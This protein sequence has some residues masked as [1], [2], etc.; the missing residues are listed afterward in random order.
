MTCRKCP[1]N[2]K[3]SWRSG[4]C[5]YLS[6]AN[7]EAANME[8]PPSTYSIFAHGR[9]Y[10][11]RKWTD[12][13]AGHGALRA[14]R[15]ATRGQ[16]PDQALLEHI[17]KQRFT[18]EVID[19]GAN[20]GGYTLWLAAIC[21]LR[22]HAFEPLEYE[23]LWRNVAL[24]YFEREVTVHQVALGAE[25]GW[26]RHV[27]AGQIEPLGDLDTVPPGVEIPQHRLD[28]YE[29][30]QLAAVRVD[31][32]RNAE[33]RVLRGAELTIKRHRP[34]IYAGTS[35]AVPILEPLGY[36]LVKLLGDEEV[37]EWVYVGA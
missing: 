18:G 4:P 20:V 15:H 1:H 34:V 12:E 25:A 10:R 35:A 3:W 36:E 30:E 16:P 13:L 5:T 9:R 28:D 23:E 24:N 6:R 19:V 32:G 33:S 11:L 31:V 14:T 29:F 17:F 8:S 22:V 2:E 37:A 7:C 26:A 27:G 21:K